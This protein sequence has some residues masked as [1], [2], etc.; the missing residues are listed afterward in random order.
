MDWQLHL[1]P[2]AYRFNMGG[3]PESVR[4]CEYSVDLWSDDD[5][6]AGP[7]LESKDT[8]SSM[9]G[10]H[11]PLGTACGLSRLLRRAHVVRIDGMRRSR[12]KPAQIALA[13]LLHLDF[14]RLQRALSRPPPSP[15][16]SFHLA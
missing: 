13:G 12:N 14:H 4:N 6:Y 10:R 3:L 11:F 5:R 2:R 15:S 16:P 8:A 1:P 7:P 9:G